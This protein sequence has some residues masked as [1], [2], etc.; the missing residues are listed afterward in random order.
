ML[1]RFA[2]PLQAIIGQAESFHLCSRE[3][4]KSLTH[5]AFR[6]VLQSRTVFTVFEFRAPAVPCSLFHKIEH[7]VR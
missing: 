2:E 1:P 6:F 4:R 5:L 3:G 7:E